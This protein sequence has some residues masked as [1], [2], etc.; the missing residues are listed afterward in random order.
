LSERSFRRDHQRR[1]NAAKRRHQIKARKTAAAAVAVGA[2]AL[3]APA[4]SSAANLVV[5]SSADTTGAV[6]CA[7]P[8]NTDCTLRQAILDANANTADDTITFDSSITGTITLTGGP[9]VV[10]SS[11]PTYYGLTI[12]GPGAATLAIS[13]N[14]SSNVFH[15]KHTN[16]SPGLTISGLTLTHGSGTYAG[17]LLSEKYSTVK[18]DHV[19]VTTSTATGATDTSGPFD[20]S[21]AGGGIANRG[22]MT[23]TNS[24]ISGN[25]STTG[26]NPSG[27]YY[28][29]AGINNVGPLTVD[30]S[31]I[32]GN[33]SDHYGGGIFH[34]QT[35]Y[36]S[37][38]DVSNSTISNNDASDAGGGIASFNKVLF[39][40]SHNSV[41][42]TTI[43]GNG[44]YF[45]GG[46]AGKYVSSAEHWTISHSTLSNNNAYA[47]GGIH[48]GVVSG[49]FELLDS[50]V[51]GNDA[52]FGGGVNLDRSAAKYQNATQFNN[53]TIASNYGYFAGGGIYLGN[54]YGPNPSNTVPIPLF[55]TIVADNTN[56][57]SKNDL[58]VGNPSRDA[59]DLS[60]GLVEAP[61]N[62][63]ISQTPSGS[64]IFGVD[65]QL[66]ALGSNGGP[67]QTKLPAVTSPVVDQ[68]SAPGNLLTDQRGDPRTVDTSPANA[69]DGTDIG[70]V[71]LATG[72][73]LPSGGSAGTKV[74]GIKKKHKK[75]KHVLRTK[76]KHVKIHVTFSSGNP[77]VTFQ[78]SVD[79]GPAVPCTSPFSPSV[80]SAPGKGKIHTVTITAVDSAGNAVGKPRTIRF[81]IIRVA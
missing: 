36:P 12:T 59:F 58:A 63:T 74:H 62:A 41:V 44:A 56:Q 29:G 18:L 69:N 17:A 55:S 66:G 16:S 39:G 40:S 54:V 1:L 72:P 11:G 45:G 80:S 22:T 9:L 4:S 10:D 70:A 42:N 28:G 51:S 3:A 25:H 68:G 15:V 5:G 37:T 81:R 53:S 13:G 48:L 19:A 78:C 60:F 24:L 77:G 71:E 7:T 46:F 57:T 35:K 14:D 73:P 2:F 27:S 30:S 32:T 61:T 47:G 31:T 21:L 67:T 64:S 76:N 79:G 75:R 20:V 6:D 52:A 49:S 65:P 23:I 34:G 50:T 43:S 38:L 8:T 33:I 26:S